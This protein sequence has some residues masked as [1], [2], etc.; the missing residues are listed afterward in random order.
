[1]S[2][3]REEQQKKHGHRHLMS[4]ELI[5]I[6]ETVQRGEKVAT[7]AKQFGVTRQTIYNAD[8]TVKKGPFPPSN[9]VHTTPP[10]PSKR[11]RIMRIAPDICQQ[12]IDLSS[13]LTTHYHSRIHGGTHEKPVDRF[14][15]GTLR[16]PDPPTYNN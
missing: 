1:M 10:L 5:T 8:R 14:G 16:L 2:N 3:D 15:Q 12:L 6:E 9:D 11:K 7:L 4:L 13:Y